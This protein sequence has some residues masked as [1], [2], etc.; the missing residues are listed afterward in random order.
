MSSDLLQLQHDLQQRV[1]RPLL[2]SQPAEHHVETLGL[3]R[4]PGQRVI[5]RLTRLRS[6]AGQERHDKKRFAVVAGS[7]SET[8]RGIRSD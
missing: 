6:Q 4:P 2:P 1:Q 8:P 7:G 5:T 3:N